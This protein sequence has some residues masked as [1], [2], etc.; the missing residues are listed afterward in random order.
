[1]PIFS[2]SDQQKPYFDTLGT[3]RN[4]VSI[5]NRVEKKPKNYITEAIETITVKE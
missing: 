3:E 1:M 4:E 5:F 2:S